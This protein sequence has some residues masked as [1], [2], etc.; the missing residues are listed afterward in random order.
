MKKLFLF[1]F[2]LLL[3]AMAFSQT[4]ID[5]TYEEL[6][7]RE[8][9]VKTTTAA[10]RVVAMEDHMMVLQFEKTTGGYD[11]FT[12]TIGP[13]NW[14]KYF[15]SRM[16][17]IDDWVELDVINAELKGIGPGGSNNVA[18]MWNLQFLQRPITIYESPEFRQKRMESWQSK[19]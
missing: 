9:A 15:L 16:I 5:T 13:R 7:T 4:S 19:K 6:K 2:L 14:A 8:S 17:Q 18:H 1:S 11:L 12:I 10:G 3:T